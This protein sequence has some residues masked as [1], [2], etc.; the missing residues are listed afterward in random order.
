MFDQLFDRML[1]CLMAAVLVVPEP[2]TFF[3]CLLLFAGIVGH[4]GSFVS[5]LIRRDDAA[6]LVEPMA[7]EELLAA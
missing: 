5:G 6:V 3:V 7:G 1:Y 2:T 4:C